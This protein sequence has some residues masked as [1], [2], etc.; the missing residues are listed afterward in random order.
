MRKEYFIKISQVAFLP[1]P[2]ASASLRWA[3]RNQPSGPFVACKQNFHFSS[4]TKYFN[5]K[6]C[7]RQAMIFYCHIENTLCWWHVVQGVCCMFWKWYL[8]LMDIQATSGFVCV[9][10]KGVL[11][12]QKQRNA[13]NNSSWVLSCPLTRINKQTNKKAKK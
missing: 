6:L 3:R 7:W 8:V 12:R 13:D 11:L 10:L 5:F 9:H 1:S 4:C 2:L